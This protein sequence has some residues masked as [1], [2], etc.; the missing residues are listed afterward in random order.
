MAAKKGASKGAEKGKPGRKKSDKKRRIEIESQIVVQPE[1]SWDRQFGES[2]ES[3]QRF[4]AYRDL[5]YRSIGGEKLFFDPTIERKS[6]D[7]A[8]MFGVKKCT[9]DREI[10][11]KQWGK[12]CADYDVYIQ[13]KKNREQ[14]MEVQK[15]MVKTT[16]ISKALLHTAMVE[17][18][19][20]LNPKKVGVRDFLEVLKYAM[21]L[22]SQTLGIDY[23]RKKMFQLEDESARSKNAAGLLADFVKVLSESAGENG[24]ETHQDGESSPVMPLEALGEKEAETHSEGGENGAGG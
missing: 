20:R 10:S 2:A 5:P 23:Y 22:E 24:A 19:P 1:Y 3:Y 14:E 16:R 11:D 17:W 6:A 13:G 9:I 12:R 21:E 4:I 8:R 15:A 7:V 18:F